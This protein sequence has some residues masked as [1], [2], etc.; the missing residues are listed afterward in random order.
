MSTYLR[1]RIIDVLFSS[2]EPRIELSLDEIRSILG[3]DDYLVGTI[4][5]EI[6]RMYYSE[7]LM[8]DGRNLVLCH[9]TPTQWGEQVRFFFTSDVTD[10][11][12]FRAWRAQRFSKPHVYHDY[13]LSE[14]IVFSED[15]EINRATARLASVI[16]QLEGAA[17]RSFRDDA[18]VM[19]ISVALDVL[20][21]AAA[22]VDL[23]SGENE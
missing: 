17:A 20:Q 8:P 3:A 22:M 4:Y 12:A 9:S 7:I 19:Q 18:L 10:I 14:L 5:D 21:S 23:L 1:S 15:S 16:R 6:K 2:S 11:K 13:A